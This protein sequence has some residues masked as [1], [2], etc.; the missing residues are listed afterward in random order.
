MLNGPVCTLTVHLR[1][2]NTPTFAIN[3]TAVHQL[4][5]QNVDNQATHAVTTAVVS[6]PSTRA[7]GH[8]ACLLLLHWLG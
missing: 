6:Q 7:H 3:N 2:K 8:M 4:G 1:D 5:C